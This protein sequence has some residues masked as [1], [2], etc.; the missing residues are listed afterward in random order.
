MSPIILLIAVLA[1]PQEPTPS[2]TGGTRDPVA[3]FERWTGARLVFTRKEAPRQVLYA[4]TPALSAER[5]RQA[6]EILYAHALNYP[7]G[8]F[9]KIGLTTVAVFAGCGDPEGDGFRPWVESLNGYR[10]FGRWHEVGAIA[11]CYYDDVQLPLTFH[12]E[13]FHHIDATHAG[14]TAYRYFSSDDDRFARALSGDEPYPGLELDPRTLRSLRAVAGGHVLEEAVARYAQK[15]AGEDQAETARWLQTNLADGLIQAA[16]RPELAGSQRILH[17][18]AEYHKADAR[19]S[20]SWFIGVALGQTGEAQRR[21]AEPEPAPVARDNPYLDKVDAEIDD[22]DVRRAIRGV[23]PA[24]VRLGGGSGVN[25][26]PAG[27]ILTAG[28]VADAVGD[29][30]TVTFPDG[31]RFSGV[32]IA[33][34]DFL[35][36]GLVRLDDVP[37]DARLPIARLAPSAPEV[38]DPVVVIGQPGRRTPSGEPTDYE[39]WHVSVGSIRGFL[40]DRLGRQSLGRA[41]HSAWTYW[42]HSGSPLFDTRGRIVAL[43]NSWD[44][45]T[46]MRH[47]VPWEAIVH[48]L[49]QTR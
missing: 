3:A 35:D 7:K 45:R 47:A 28:H 15:S 40:P 14:R 31:R 36:L 16:V 29:R 5:R 10:Y 27:L 42:G 34:D 46:A 21:H 20:T 13:V 48:F 44:S 37:A 17:L 2:P 1:L 41:K 9:A 30:F 12:H 39:P 22:P 4:T 33:S 25:I 6:A 8:L 26:D 23:Q 18:L 11:A 24:T 19:L 49:D 43:H 38:G 32:T